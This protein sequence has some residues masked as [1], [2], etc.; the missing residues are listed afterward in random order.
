MQNTSFLV[1][2][3][4]AALRRLTQATIVAGVAL[5]PQT[6]EQVKPASPAGPFVAMTETAV[7]RFVSAVQ[8]S[9]DE[10]VTG[11]SEPGR[12]MTGEEA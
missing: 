9:D 10:I 5:T 8:N 12:S 2:T 4:W 1:I 3:S 7:V 11:K 6:A